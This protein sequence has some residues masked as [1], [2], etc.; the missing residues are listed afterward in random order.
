MSATCENTAANFTERGFWDMLATMQAQTL[1]AAPSPAAVSSRALVSYRSVLWAALLTYPFVPALLYQSSSLAAS[2]SALAVTSVLLAYAWSITGPVAAWFSLCEAD[3]ARLNRRERPQ[4]VREAILAA[5]GAPF[6]VL[7]GVVLRWVRLPGEQAA[8][9]YLVLAGVAA[10]RWLPAPQQRLAHE[11]IWQR[12][13]RISA[14]LLVLFGVA[15]VGNH[16]AAVDSLQAHVSV[17]NALRTVYRWP[18]IE[19]LIVI[20]ALV[21]VGTGWVTVARA[22]LQRS[23]GLRNLQVLAGA[24]LGMFFLSHLTGVFGGR[25]QHTDTTFAWATGGAAGLIS[26]PRLGSFLPYYSLAVFAF[27]VHA[28]TAGRWMLAGPLGESRALKVCY[29]LLGLSGVV[30]LALLLP[31]CGVRLG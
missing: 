16:L 11:Y 1:A 2:S 19:A 13:H 8:L 17:Q 14:I 3:R 7:S 18:A 30:T 21:Q 31:L 10:A 23:N 25:L 22:R 9:W 20:A 15:H 6:F 12:I 4:L 26:T 28:A 24:Y 27:L 29:G 5:I